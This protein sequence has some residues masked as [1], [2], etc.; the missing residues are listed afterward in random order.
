MR[1]GMEWTTHQHMLVH[2][3]IGAG[4]HYWRSPQLGSGITRLHEVW[5]YSGLTVLA[6]HPPVRD[7]LK[8]KT[9]KQ[10]HP[11]VCA[12]AGAGDRLNLI[13]Q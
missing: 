11:P 3:K 5:V 9:A 6:T 10:L 7:G 12:L 13:T 2:A 1:Y 4:R 8:L